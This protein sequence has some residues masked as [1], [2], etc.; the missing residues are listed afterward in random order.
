MGCGLRLGSARW[1]LSSFQIT[2]F[3]II[4]EHVRNANFEPL[5]PTPDL[6][7]QLLWEHGPG[8]CVVTAFLWGQG[9]GGEGG[10]DVLT[11]QVL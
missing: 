3:S 1:R 11:S 5:H 10:E 9:E 8:M 2:S 6:L 7:T 4:W